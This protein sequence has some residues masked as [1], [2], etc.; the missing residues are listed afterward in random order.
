MPILRVA[1]TD[2][3]SLTRDAVDVERMYWQNKILFEDIYMLH[4]CN[5]SNVILY[6]ISSSL[7]MYYT[8]DLYILSEMCTHIEFIHV[9]IRARNLLQRLRHSNFEASNLY[10]F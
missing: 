10:I 2:R 9:I 4:T 7:C 1:E 3:A 6:C 8:L 5:K